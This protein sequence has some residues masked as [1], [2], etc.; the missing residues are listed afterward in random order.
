MR[1]TGCLREDA[2]A[3]VAAPRHAPSGLAQV[4][5]T[6]EMREIAAVYVKPQG[7][8]DALPDPKEFRR[9]AG[10]FPWYQL[11]KLRLVRDI[12]RLVEISPPHFTEFR[13]AILRISAASHSAKNPQ[14][15]R[16]VSK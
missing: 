7:R 14:A 11:V 4:R 13:Y 12:A 1:R 10:R 3:R 15:A 2:V 9:A 16:S 5:L 6:V 8:Q